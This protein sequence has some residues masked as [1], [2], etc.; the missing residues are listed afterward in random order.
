MCRSFAARAK[1]ALLSSSRRTMS[2]LAAPFFFTRMEL[3]VFFT[4]SPSWGAPLVLPDQRVLTQRDGH[5]L[6]REAASQLL[7]H[8]FV[9]LPGDT[10]HAHRV[11]LSRDQHVAQRHELGHPP[12]R[13][14]LVPKLRTI[15]QIDARL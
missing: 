14:G 5:H 2:G 12:A 11:L 15:I 4:N 6:D 13:I 3:F 1:N 10:E 8:I 9:I 7:R